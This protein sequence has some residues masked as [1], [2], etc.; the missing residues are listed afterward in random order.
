MRLKKWIRRDAGS[1]ITSTPMRVKTALP[2]PEEAGRRGIP[3]D[4]GEATHREP[5]CLVQLTTHLTAWWA[6][7]PW[8][9]PWLMAIIAARLGSRPQELRHPTM[10]VFEMAS[11][12]LSRCL[13][14]VACTGTHIC[15]CSGPQMPC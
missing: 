10:Y 13:G 2:T 7:C 9:R 15:T 6:A 11:A 8:L 3:D 12:Q 5:V 14:H 1:V 4:E